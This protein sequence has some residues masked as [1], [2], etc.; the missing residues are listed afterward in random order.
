MIPSWSSADKLKDKRHVKD[1]DTVAMEAEI[2]RA[3]SK[4]SWIKERSTFTKHGNA[5]R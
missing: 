2:T 1:N 4:L 5:W 3:I